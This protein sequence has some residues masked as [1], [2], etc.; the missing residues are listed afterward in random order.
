MNNKYTPRIETFH[1]SCKKN[2]TWVECAENLTKTKLLKE[3][4]K[5]IKPEL[6]EFSEIRISKILK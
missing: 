3:L 2:G 1:L 6:N 4:A 5:I